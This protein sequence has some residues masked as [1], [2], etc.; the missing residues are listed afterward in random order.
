MKDYIAAQ[1]RRR[2]ESEGKRVDVDSCREP[3]RQPTSQRLHREPHGRRRV[4]GGELLPWSNRLTT[5]AV[6]A[7]PVP[8]RIS[9]GDRGSLIRK[10]PWIYVRW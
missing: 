8:T 3:T 1:T 10:I 9:S 2:E 6:T 4:R 5:E 7:A